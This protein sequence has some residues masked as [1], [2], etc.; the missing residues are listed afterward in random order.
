MQT[1]PPHR[2]TTLIS[3]VSFI[4]TLF[5]GQFTTVPVSLVLES[6][7]V[8]QISTTGDDLSTNVQTKA[9]KS[10]PALKM[11]WIFSL[12]CLIPKAFLSLSRVFTKRQLMS[13]SLVLD[14]R[15][16]PRYAGVRWADE[17][18]PSTDVLLVNEAREDSKTRVSCE[19]ILFAAHPDPALWIV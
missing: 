16:F 13:Q 2:R 15:D 19:S 6:R 11:G 18:Q 17:V 3:S 5:L 9:S 1:L 10:C 4:V 14:E 8:H 7:N 12:F